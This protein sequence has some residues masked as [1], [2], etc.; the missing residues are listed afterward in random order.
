M[1]VCHEYNRSTTLCVSF[2]LLVLWTRC[3]ASRLLHCFCAI[4]VVA[5]ALIVRSSCYARVL[6]DWIDWIMSGCRRESDPL[7]VIISG[8][9][10]RLMSTPVDVPGRNIPND[11][12]GQIS[13]SPDMSFI[14]CAMSPEHFKVIL[15]SYFMNIYNRFKFAILLN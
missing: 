15:K 13:T 7:W 6:L 9:I 1:R 3:F 4:S 12:L 8:L 14:E 2:I 10:D 11:S 5:L